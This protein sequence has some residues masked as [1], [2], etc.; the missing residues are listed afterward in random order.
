MRRERGNSFKHPPAW[1]PDN[2]DLLHSILMSKKFGVYSRQ[3]VFLVLRVA[4]DDRN[5]SRIRVK[6][7]GQINGLLSAR[8]DRYPGDSGPCLLIGQQSADRHKHYG[9]TGEHFVAVL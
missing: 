8:G 7:K 9:H 2:V 1:R 4:G 5:S 6:T 3:I